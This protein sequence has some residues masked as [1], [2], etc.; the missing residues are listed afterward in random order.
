MV[1]LTHSPL[2]T[3]LSAAQQKLRQPSLQ[4]APGGLLLGL[5]FNPEDGG[6]MSLQNVGLFP[7]Y[8]TQKTMPSKHYSIML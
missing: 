5:L 7:N 6:N 4:P 8:T 3:S 1:K 2:P